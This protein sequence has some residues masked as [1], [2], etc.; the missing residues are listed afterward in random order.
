MN[1]LDGEIKVILEKKDGK[2]IIN[3]IFHKGVLKVSPT[4]YLDKE[5]IPC[6]FFMHMGGGYIEGESCSNYIELK[7]GSR[8]VITTQAPTIIYQSRNEKICKQYSM[9][10]LEEDSVLEYILDNTILFKDARYEQNTEIHLHKSSSLIYAD[11]ITAG[12]SPDNKKFQYYIA[13]M[14]SKIYMDGNLIFL[15]NLLFEPKNQDLEGLG[16][17]EG[18]SNYG[19]ATVID[20]RIDDIFVENLKEYI[21]SFN[22][23][24]KFGISM[25][26]VNG[27][28]IR[29]IGNLTQDIQKA[30]YICINHV[31]KK[32]FNS[33]DLNL[34][35]Y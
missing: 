30:L 19:T 20:R 24:I 35:K 14:K 28:V 15:D 17:L 3:D 18:Y 27:F 11:G 25:L 9:I 32:L 26:E 22:L 34:R 31:R 23:D 21:E 10:N 7:K 12:W 33:C 16:F 1:D 13:H 8:C 6:Y 4:I 29:I 2:T 5:K